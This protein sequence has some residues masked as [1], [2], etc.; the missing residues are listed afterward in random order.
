MLDIIAAIDIRYFAAATI[1]SL[2]DAASAFCHTL[3]AAMPE[4]ADGF[5]M[6]A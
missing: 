4:F 2:P 1:R 3:I 5:A 6:I